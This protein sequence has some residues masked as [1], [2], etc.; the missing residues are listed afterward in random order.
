MDFR[1]ANSMDLN[2][3]CDLWNAEVASNG[4]YKA[5]TYDEFYTRFALNE[6]FSYDSIFVCYDEDLLVGYII[7]FIRSFYKNNPEAPAYINAIVVK[8]EYRGLL[9]GDKLLSML[10]N[11]FMEKSIKNVVVASYLP[12]CYSWYIPRFAPDDHPCAPAVRVNSDEYF[13]LLHHRYAAVGFEDAFHLPLSEYELSPSV[14]EIL[15]RNEKDGLKIEFYDSQKH[16]GLEEFY[17]DIKAPDFEKVIK[18]NLALDEP[19]PFLVISQNGKVVGWTGALWNEES[20]R[21]HFDGIIISESVRG[22]GL[23]KALFATLAYK[24]KLNGAKFM[25]FY[26]G[27]N[28]HARYI[29]MGAGF[30]IVQTYAIMKKVLKYEK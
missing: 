7:G 13:F 30:K 18:A 2:A 8:K 29:Y 16:Y 14:K 4:F 19:K 6:D 26:T 23:G 1:K 27:L 10:E 22:K 17:Q 20:G 12:L 11:Y 28:N 9:V 25:T 21:G 15:D 5:L 3:I 24:S